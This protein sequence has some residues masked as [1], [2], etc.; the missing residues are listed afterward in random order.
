[1]TKSLPARAPGNGSPPHRFAAGL[2]VSA[3]LGGLLL[4]GGALLVPRDPAT[5]AL[6][7]HEAGAFVLAAAAL[8]ALALG[9]RGGVWA[10]LRWLG[11]LALIGVGVGRISGWIAQPEFLLIA[12]PGAFPP[13]IFVTAASLGLAVLLIERPGRYLPPAQGLAALAMTLAFFSF[14]ADWFRLGIVSLPALMSGI[15]LQMDALVLVASAAVLSLS[16]SG[17]RD[18]LAAQTP[19][20]YMVRRLAPLAIGIPLLVGWLRVEGERGGLFSL[21]VGL[22]LFATIAV[23]LMLVA[24]LLIAQRLNREH[25]Y[26]SAAEVKLDRLNRELEDKIARRT[27]RLEA[28]VEELEAFSYSVSHD[29]RAP[30]RAIDG[31]SRIL[32]EEKSD[33]LDGEGEGHLERIRSASARMARL[34]DDLLSLSRLSRLTLRWRPVDLS[35]LAGEI[36]TE[37]E[38]GEPDRN[39]DWI[40]QPDLQAAGDPTLLRAALENLLGNAWKFTAGEE[41]AQ[42]EFGRSADDPNHYFVRDN[43]VGFDMHYAG[44]LFGAF[45]RLHG[46]HEYPGSG[47][48]LATVKRIIHRHDGRLWAEAVDGDGATFHFTLPRSYENDA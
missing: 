5:G 20:G 32:L 43:G 41:N 48:G 18:I 35:R 9:R 40:I 38:A 23:I 37:L 36:A 17:L 26:R 8:L 12:D 19:G 28:T 4:A 3:L 16:P 22:A 27:A 33:R 15:F 39:V 1:M 25:A 29:L 42:I 47:I 30:L 21:E 44:K 7:A 14:S 10:A 31:F 13:V 6:L 46:Q 2:A 24:V 11:G 45:Q 34:I